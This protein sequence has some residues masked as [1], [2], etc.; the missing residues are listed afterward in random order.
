MCLFMTNPTQITQAGGGAMVPSVDEKVN[1][2]LKVKDSLGKTH[3]MPEKREQI[4]I[5]QTMS[6]LSPGMFP[7][8]M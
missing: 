3:N 1:S 7:R 4:H 2:C 5:Q 8:Q 6:T